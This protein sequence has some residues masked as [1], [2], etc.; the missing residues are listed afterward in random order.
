MIEEP[1]TTV[2]QFSRED[3]RSI[4]EN[5]LSDGVPEETGRTLRRLLE[6][7]YSREDAIDKI[8]DVVVRELNEVLHTM[9]P[10][11]ER[12][13]TGRLRELK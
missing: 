13:F 10:F 6:A 7:G 11:D 3:I 2:N 12:R 5:Q 9:Q 1:E 8:G 4:V